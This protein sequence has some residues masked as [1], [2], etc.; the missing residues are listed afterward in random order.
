[1]EVKLA[2]NMEAIV[3]LENQTYTSGGVR[4]ENTTGSLLPST[5]GMGTIL[6]ITIGSIMVIGFGV[7]LVAKLRLSREV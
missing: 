3:N 4:V 1:M 7:L 6:F 2:D 5:G